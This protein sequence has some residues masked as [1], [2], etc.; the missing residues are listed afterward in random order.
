MTEKRYHGDH[1]PEDPNVEPQMIEL[2]ADFSNLQSGLLEALS[3]MQHTSPLRTLVGELKVF[4]SQ[5]C[6]EEKETI[7]YFDE[8]IGEMKLCETCKGVFAFLTRYGAWTFLHYHLVEVVNQEFQLGCDD[9]I[10]VYKEKIV[11]FMEVTTLKDFLT[12][13]NHSY[14]A[15][16]PPEYDRLVVKVKAKWSTYTLAR[17]AEV[18]SYLTGEF[19]LKK[20]VLLLDDGT[21]G[22]IYLKWLVPSLVG[23]YMWRRM[24]ESDWPKQLSCNIEEL[25]IERIMVSFLIAVVA[26]VPELQILKYTHEGRPGNEARF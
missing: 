13:W 1:T 12:L 10:T 26:Q 4:L 6:A 25:R 18:E 17:V 8:R 20:L 9:K 2:E 7:Y 15:P 23:E 16:T 11:P 5:L 22:C 3:R 19:K 14:E 24:N 21:F